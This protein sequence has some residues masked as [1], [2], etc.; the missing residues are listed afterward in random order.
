[1]ALSNNHKKKIHVKAKRRLRLTYLR[2]LRIDDPPE[3]IARGVAIG[4]CMGILPTFG[5]GIILSFVIALI[6]KANK[7][8]AVLGSF[9]M[10]PLT[11]PLF[12]SA[13]IL[14]GSLITG[15]S[16]GAILRTIREEGLLRGAGWTY[17]VFMAGNVI[18]TGAFTAASYFFSKW[19]IIRHRR[20]KA[21][22]MAR[23]GRA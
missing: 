5:A 10:N 17:A 19:F 12:W 3:R 13:S 8:A 7:A 21:E 9:I 1:M 22:K 16:Y 4:V 6:L 15:Q 20:R 14:I 11:T 18:V 23:N 2:I